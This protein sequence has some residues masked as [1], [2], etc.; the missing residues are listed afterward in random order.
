MCREEFI[1]FSHLR[2][3]FR[4]NC[5]LWKDF[6]IKA[7]MAL[8]DFWGIL[9]RDKKKL[10]DLPH[11][12]MNFQTLVDNGLIGQ[13]RLFLCAGR[14]SDFDRNIHPCPS[15]HINLNVYRSIR[16]IK[17]GLKIVKTILCNQWTGPNFILYVCMNVKD[18]QKVGSKRYPHSRYLLVIKETQLIW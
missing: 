2:K 7:F 6:F 17:T 16:I 4:I 5:K 10:K 18:P 14:I 8:N 13:G 15:N 12:A 1:K 9:L 3:S 11:F